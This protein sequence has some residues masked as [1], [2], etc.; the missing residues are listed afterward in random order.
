LRFWLPKKKRTEK[1][2]RK[3]K[4]RRKETME[5]PRILRLVDLRSP[6]IEGLSWKMNES[7]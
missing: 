6:D 5:W 4:N 7:E 1:K 2:K 3:E